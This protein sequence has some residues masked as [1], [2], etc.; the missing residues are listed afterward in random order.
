MPILDCG[1]NDNDIERWGPVARPPGA[2]DVRQLGGDPAAGS[3]TATLLRLLPSCNPHA[4]RALENMSHIK[5]TPFSL[6]HRG[7]VHKFCGEFGFNWHRR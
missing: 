5:T 1:W 2:P 7:L 3:P 4:R 6:A